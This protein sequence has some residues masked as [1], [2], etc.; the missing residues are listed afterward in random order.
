MIIDQIG[1][2]DDL[3]KMIDGT[4]YQRV[5]KYVLRSLPGGFIEDKLALLPNIHNIYYRGYLGVKFRI[6]DEKKSHEYK[7]S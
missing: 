4:P 2:A 1:N 3:G 5:P 6:N 7:R